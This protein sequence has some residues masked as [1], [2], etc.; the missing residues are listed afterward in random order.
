MS[1]ADVKYVRSEKQNVFDPICVGSLGLYT[2]F[3]FY[4]D[5]VIQ[6]SPDGKLNRVAEF[7]IKKL[8]QE[9]GDS[10]NISSTVSNKST[11]AT[12]LKAGW[13]SDNFN[14]YYLDEGGVRHL[15]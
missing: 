12:T 8:K 3:M 4:E 13:Y 5:K 2:I 10:N 14:T 6:W 15:K 1:T 7:H 11:N 9:L